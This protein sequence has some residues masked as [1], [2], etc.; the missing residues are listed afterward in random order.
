MKKA[1]FLFSL[2]LATVLANNVAT[3]QTMFQKVI[4][5][6]AGN[7]LVN[8]SQMTSDSGQIL[9]GS[10]NGLTRVLDHRNTC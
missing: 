9:V 5:G 6:T 3:A 4:G 2:F 8:Y 7:E 1:G 10:T